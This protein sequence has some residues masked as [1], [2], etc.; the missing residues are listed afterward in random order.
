MSWD[1]LPADYID[2]LVFNLDSEVV[3]AINVNRIQIGSEVEDCSANETTD[4]H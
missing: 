4:V 2:S 3:S 1:S